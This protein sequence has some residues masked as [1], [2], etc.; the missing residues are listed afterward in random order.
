MT[1]GS[2]VRLAKKDFFRSFKINNSERFSLKSFMH[3]SFDL[4][5]I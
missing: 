2:L 3:S 5:D 1:V 4:K